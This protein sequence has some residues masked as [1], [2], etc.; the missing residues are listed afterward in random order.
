MGDRYN[1]FAVV[2]AA[3]MLTAACDRGAEDAPA[4][5]ATGAATALPEAQTAP[6]EPATEAAP[7]PPAADA[8]EP[9]AAVDD[10]PP[11]P[12]L[13]AL[14]RRVGYV[15]ADSADLADFVHL[16]PGA[17][18]QAGAFGHDEETVRV[19]LISYPNSRY[20]R[21][22]FVDVQ[23]R[24]NVLPNPREAALVNGRYLVHIMAR[25]L[26]TANRVRDQ[27]AETLQWPV[28]PSE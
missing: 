3:A 17:T 8:T 9:A 14:M 23:T 24:V 10:T 6:D 11:P 21:P 18:G 20:A 12:S 25:D 2:S 4:E 27:I 1:W 19:A 5:P 16:P 13:P 15:E 28:R 7:T 22:H 26:D